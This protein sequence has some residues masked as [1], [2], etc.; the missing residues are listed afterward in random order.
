MMGD[1]PLGPEPL[2]PAESDLIIALAGSFNLPVE[3]GVMMG[4]VW[5]AAD[6][7][8][9]ATGFVDMRRGLEL[10]EAGDLSSGL[11]C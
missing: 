8:W 7:L 3:V 1:T 9:R 11:G 5:E 6:E 2:D 10:D 4:D